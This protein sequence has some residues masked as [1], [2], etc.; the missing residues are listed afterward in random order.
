EADFRGEEVHVA[1][2]AEGDAQDRP[3]VPERRDEPGAAKRAFAALLEEGARRLERARLELLWSMRS[4]EAARR[5][6]RSRER[7]VQQRAAFARADGVADGVFARRAEHA[8]EA[9][10]PATQGAFERRHRDGAIVGGGHVCFERADCA[11]VRPR[12]APRYGIEALALDL[13]RGA[14]TRRRGRNRQRARAP[15]ARC[16]WRRRLASKRG[17][18]LGEP[19]GEAARPERARALVRRE[20]DRHALGVREH[21]ARGEQERTPLAAEHRALRRR[22]PGKELRTDY[23]VDA[24]AAIEHLVACLA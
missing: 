23:G 5:F 16:E 6:E 20:R 4:R 9:E 10:E 3:H 19:E 15:R 24:V 18:L 2:F 8:H 12:R 22:E 7:A 1:R 14:P 21:G 13:D 17:A 11:R